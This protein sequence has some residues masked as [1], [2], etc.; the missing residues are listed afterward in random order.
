MGLVAG[1][2]VVCFLLG[3]RLLFILKNLKMTL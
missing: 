2:G 1:L 3:L